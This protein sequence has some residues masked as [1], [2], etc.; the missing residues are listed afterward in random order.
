MNKNL[1][2][3]HVVASLVATAT[4]ATFLGLAIASELA[5]GFTAT[6][7]TS[8]LRGLFV[9]V[10]ALMAIG[11]TGLRLARN[12]RGRLVDDKL[13]RMKLVAINGV[14]ILLPCAIWL[15]WRANGGHFDTAFGVVQ[16]IELAAG[17]A[18]LR[19][20]LLNLRDG[21]RLSGGRRPASIGR[22]IRRA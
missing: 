2:R 21:L 11:I 19:L 12:H 18:N 14:F 7:R 16:L 20:L 9:L 1:V 5:P 22:V 3:V 15:A 10:P 6:A 13:R 4:V 8:I 17:A